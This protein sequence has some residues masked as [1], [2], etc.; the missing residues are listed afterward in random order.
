MLPTHRA[1]LSLAIFGARTLD[2]KGSVSLPPSL[3]IC[4]TSVLPAFSVTK[5]FPVEH[6]NIPSCHHTQPHPDSQQES[7]SSRCSLQSIFVQT[8][9]TFLPIATPGAIAE[10]RDLS[11]LVYKVG[12]QQEV[13]TDLSAQMMKR[14]ADAVLSKGAQHG[15][16]QSAKASLGQMLKCMEDAVQVS[17]SSRCNALAAVTSPCHSVPLLSPCLP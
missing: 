11:H 12:H 6:S 15:G 8:F 13:F 3:P 1:S 7:T 10:W 16:I 9:L 2:Q 14:T 5:T 17:L 4:S